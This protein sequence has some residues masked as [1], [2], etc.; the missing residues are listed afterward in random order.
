MRPSLAAAG[1][2]WLPR[3]AIHGSGGEQPVRRPKKIGLPGRPVVA[4][5]AALAAY[6]PRGA[7]AFTIEVV[8]DMD[9][10]SRLRAAAV[11]LSREN[12]HFDPLSQSWKRP[13][14]E[15]SWSDFSLSAALSRQ[16]VSPNAAIGPSVACGRAVCVRRSRPSLSRA[17]SAPRRQEPGTRRRRPR[18]RSSVRRRRRHRSS[19][20]RT[21]S[22]E[23][24][25]R[26]RRPRR[27]RRK[28][29]RSCRTVPRQ[30]SAQAQQGRGQRRPARHHQA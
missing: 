2:C 18:G 12:G 3:T 6:I 27:A 17:G 29:S 30:G 23:W 22:K 8:A 9:D 24:R 20:T 16:P 14:P 4:I 1:R 13:A 10:K 28:P 21:C 11:A 15:W 19:G 25:V 5:R 7:W 26:L